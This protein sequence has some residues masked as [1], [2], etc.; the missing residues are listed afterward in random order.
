VRP[1]RK[2]DYYYFA[3]GSNM[4]PARVAERGVRTTAAAGAALEGV[5]LAFNKGAQAHAA[6]GH[7]NICHDA[8]A[9]VEGVLYRLAGADE[10]VRMDHFEATP[11]NYSRDLV[12]VRCGARSVWAWTY[13]AN[14]A[15]IVEGL[16]PSRSYL[17]HLLAGRPFLSDPY[18]ACLAAWPCHD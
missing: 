14:P 13:V 15:V 17:A 9:R 11:I 3:Y 18:Y 5:R 4:N 1:V 7:A 10:I 8:G 6:E 2:R 12:A 16:R